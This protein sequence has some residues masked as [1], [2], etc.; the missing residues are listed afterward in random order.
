MA[1]HLRISGPLFVRTRPWRRPS[2]LLVL[3]NLSANGVLVSVKVYGA[4]FS[5]FDTATTWVLLVDDDFPLATGQ[6]ETVE[7]LVDP[8]FRLYQFH[9]ENSLPNL[10]FHPSLYLLTSRRKPRRAI[11]LVVG[12][13]WE[14]Q[15]INP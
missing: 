1:S 9:V 6:I 15:E 14:M 4:P 5:G 3:S 11:P 12:N 10:C 2:F 13:E 8:N 7:I